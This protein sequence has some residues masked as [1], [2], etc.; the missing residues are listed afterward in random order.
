MGHFEFYCELCGA[1]FSI[2]RIRRD[3][4]PQEAAWDAYGRGFV[5]HDET[6]PCPESSGCKSGRDVI[7]GD[8]EETEHIAGPGC[9]SRSGYSG[10][11]ISMEEMKVGKDLLFIVLI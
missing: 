6:D 1:G 10:H 4:E 8:K 5:S 11:R 7:L 2:A 9:E 3:D